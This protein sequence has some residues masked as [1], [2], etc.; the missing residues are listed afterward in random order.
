MSEINNDRIKATSSI[1]EFFNWLIKTGEIEIINSQLISGKGVEIFGVRRAYTDEHI[2]YKFKGEEEIYTIVKPDGDF[3]QKNEYGQIIEE[4]YEKFIEEMKENGEYYVQGT[5][6][7]RHSIQEENG[8]Y[9]SEGFSSDS[10]SAVIL[11]NGEPCLI[12]N[13]VENNHRNK[14][15]KDKTKPCIYVSTENNQK[16]YAEL[17]LEECLIRS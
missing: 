1:E 7:P 9:Y 11:K 5:S 8:I 6:V 2:Q 15:C 4:L 14:F 13:D 12:L 16:G 10:R 17:P 3:L